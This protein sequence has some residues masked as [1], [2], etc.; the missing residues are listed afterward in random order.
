MTASRTARVGAPAKVNLLL[1]VLDRRDD[2]FHELETLF[3]AVDLQDDVRV[4]V[5]PGVTGRVS[6]QLDGPDLGAPE[7]NLAVRAARA[8][9]AAAVI[10]DVGVT[11]RLV[12]RTPAGA[13]LGG[14]SSDAAAVLR[15]LGALHPGRVAQDRLERLALE[16][17]SDVPF[18]LGPGAFAVGRGRGERLTPLPPLPTGH[19]V[20][21]LPPVHVAT[22]GAYAALA[23][24]RLAHPRDPGAPA[25][26][27][28]AGWGW[29]EVAA[30]AM[31][32][33]EAVVPAAHPPVAAAL[34]A[35][36]AVGAR[37][38]LLSGSGA[39]C[40]GLF[41]DAAAAGRAAETL[42]AR[43]EVPTV[44]IRTLTSLPEVELW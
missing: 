9:L 2:G 34:E 16:L 27:P 18:F 1:R 33:F 5:G 4:Q 38:A 10:V 32:D 31:N 39:A 40:F 42:T 20:L 13:G 12:K 22:G 21:V 36:R 23:R 14:G 25:P 30:L 44:A 37:P 11:V 15:C 41:P 8:F 29:A 19:L 28:D 43:L 26:I 7:D 3:Q 17:G 6:L 35:L 24:H